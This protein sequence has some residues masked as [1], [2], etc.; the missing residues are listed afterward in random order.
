MGH[1]GLDGGAV[2]AGAICLLDRPLATNSH[3]TK[4]HRSQYGDLWLGWQ[5]TGLNCGA[6]GRVGSVRLHEGRPGHRPPGVPQGNP[7]P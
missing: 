3:L 1:E 2:P 7:N 5:V 4:S 6:A